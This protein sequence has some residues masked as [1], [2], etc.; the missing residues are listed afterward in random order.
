MK[1]E[2]ILF[3]DFEKIIDLNHRN[4]LTTLQRSDWE[5]LW[6]KNPYF[7]LNNDW[8]IGWKLVNN[9]RSVFTIVTVLRSCP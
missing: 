6:K 3:E 1:I 2:K 9:W 7:L 4:N 8:T 5:N